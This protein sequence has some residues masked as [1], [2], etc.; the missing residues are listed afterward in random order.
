MEPET[1]HFTIALAV[2]IR[3]LREH[4]RLS[5]EELADKLGLHRNTIWKWERGEGQMPTIVF[6]RLCATL[7]ADAGQVLERIIHTPTMKGN[8]R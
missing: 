5:Q 6:L 2:Q 3:I 7:D 1:E 8:P 4:A